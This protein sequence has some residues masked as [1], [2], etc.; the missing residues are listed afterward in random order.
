MSGNHAQ[1]IEYLNRAIESGSQSVTSYM[2]LSDLYLK[3]GEIEKA[4]KTLES[5]LLVDPFEERS[6]YISLPEPAA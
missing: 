3:L 4:E 1:A 5:V 6:L 2:L